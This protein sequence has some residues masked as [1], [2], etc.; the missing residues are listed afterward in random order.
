MVRVYA[1]YPIN[2]NVEL[3]SE[4]TVN[5]MILKI[6][7]SDQPLEDCVIITK[8]LKIEYDELMN[9]IDNITERCD[10]LNF[11]YS[12]DS[13]KRKVIDNLCT[14]VSP[15]HIYGIYI[16]K[17]AL[18]YLK[19]NVSD[20]IDYTFLIPNLKELKVISTIESYTLDNKN[21]L[22]GEK[23]YKPYKNRQDGTIIF[24]VI[25]IVLLLIL[26]YLYSTID[27]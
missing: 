15:H 13:N 14:N 26:L 5:K 12:L 8:E 20:Q 1:T 2:S 3:C 10:V 6:I 19:E 16:K 17:N 7:T 27:C 23:E 4:S 22:R 18:E 11:G 24:F 21:L 25:T 9:M